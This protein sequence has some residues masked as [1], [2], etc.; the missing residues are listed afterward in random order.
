MS[1]G[2]R[3]TGGAD[4]LDGRA[5]L[6]R[7]I[8]RGEKLAD[9]FEEVKALT[10]VFDSEHALVELASGERAIASGERYGIYLGRGITRLYAHTHPY[11]DPSRAG[12]SDTDRLALRRLGRSFSYLLEHGDIT[13]F[14]AHKGVGYRSPGEG[15]VLTPSQPEGALQ[16]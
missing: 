7:T 10:Y 3:I 13:R 1:A 6:V 8:R 9:I 2:G 15:V 5:V 11:S 16:R 14:R 4:G 12:P